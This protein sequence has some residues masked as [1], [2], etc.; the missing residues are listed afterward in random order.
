[1]SSEQHWNQLH[2]QSQSQG[3]DRQLLNQKRGNTCHEQ[4]LSSSGSTH[5]WRV[6]SQDCTCEN[7]P[8]FLVSIVT[9]RLVL[10]KKKRNDRWLHPYPENGTHHVNGS[11]RKQLALIKCLPTQSGR[12]QSG[13]KGNNPPAN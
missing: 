4:C 2:G 9:W 8:H 10:P 3:A 5:D 11:C 6:T 12:S 7:T 1:M 13:K